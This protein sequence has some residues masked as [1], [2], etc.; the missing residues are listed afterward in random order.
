MDSPLGY[1]SE[2][3]RGSANHRHTTSS[4]R[5]DALFRNL[6]VIPRADFTMTM[7]RRS[8]SP[9]SSCTKRSSAGKVEAAQHHNRVIQGKRG[10]RE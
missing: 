5:A 6:I 8:R 10:R 4:G 3:P 9:V 2:Y 1:V 7:V